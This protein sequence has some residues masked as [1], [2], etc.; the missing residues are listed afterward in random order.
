MQILAALALALAGAACAQ[1]PARSGAGLPDDVLA[2][3]ERR[4]ACE[5]FL[6]EEGYDK[7]R[8][9]FLARQVEMYC[10]GTDKALAD[11]RKRHV[12]NPAARKALQVYEDKLGL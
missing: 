8:S 6:G 3:M 10:R 9:E 4:D 2:F 12:G 11:L 1:S 7:E 5:H